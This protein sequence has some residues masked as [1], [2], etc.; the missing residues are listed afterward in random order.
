MRG[1]VCASGAGRRTISLGEFNEFTFS[2][3]STSPTALFRIELLARLS[4]EGVGGLCIVRFSRRKP[5][6]SSDNFG[7]AQLSS[8]SSVANVAQEFFDQHSPRAL[9]HNNRS[10]NEIP[11]QVATPHPAWL[12]AQPVEPLQPGALHPDRRSANESGH[13]L[14]GTADA[15]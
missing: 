4:C 2:P 10:K 8:E 3:L 11:D 9:P 5:L 6:Q 14:K 7:F 13:H 12:E 1:D 15:H